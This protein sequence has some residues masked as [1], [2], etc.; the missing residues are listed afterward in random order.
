MRSFWNDRVADR[1]KALLRQGLTAEGLALSLAC[2]VATGLFPVIGAT[3]VLGLGIGAVLRLNMPALQLAN[4]LTYPIQLAMILPLVRL[5][6]W[7]AGAPPV[8]FSVGHIVASTSADPLGT[9]GRYGMTGLH[10]ILGWIAVGPIVVL[11]LY[12][13]LLPALRGVRVRVQPWE[14]G[15]AETSP[16]D[17]LASETQ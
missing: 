10:G 14:P 3:T 7:L 12:R 8:P 9:L 16:R 15:R 1:L 2:G 4:W 17:P 5:G 11:A 6:E 13:A